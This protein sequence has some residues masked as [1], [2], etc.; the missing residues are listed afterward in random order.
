MSKQN[1]SKLK[2][3][4]TTKEK[5]KRG[6]KKKID[7]D[8]IKK[9]SDALVSGASHKIACEA[10]GISQSSFY[11][12]I[13]KAENGEE[14]Y[15]PFLESIKGAESTGALKHLENIEK[16]SMNDWRASAWLLERRY[17]YTKEG[18][19][20]ERPKLE[21]KQEIDQSILEP[22]ELLKKQY[23]ELNKAAQNALA[24]GSFQAYSALKR[25]EL[26]VAF[27]LNRE[28]EKKGDSL[29]GDMTDQQVMKEIQYLFSALPA[30]LK[31]QI[32]NE[33]IQSKLKL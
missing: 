27:E 15:F 32:E 23:I 13:K 22:I 33:I 1:K 18:V 11:R 7:D 14:D 21:E 6:R 31:Q 17:K 2:I 10:A 29:F 5:S 24:I 16:H 19:L 26:K 8:L 3:K 28:K 9:L 30:S 12:W 4:D 25:Q 20:E